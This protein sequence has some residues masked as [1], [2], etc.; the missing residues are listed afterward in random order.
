MKLLID[1][2]PVELAGGQATTFSACCREVMQHLLKRN[3]AID[4]LLLDGRPVDSV[5]QAEADFAAAA[6]CEFRTVPL[7]DAVRGLLE[8]YER[9]LR[10]LEASVENLVTESLLAE[11]ET[12]AGLWR[13]LCEAVKLAIARLP[14]LAALLTDEEIDEIAER[15]MTDFNNAMRDI[16]TALNKADLVAFSDILE[17]RLLAWLRGIREIVARQMAS[18][19]ADQHGVRP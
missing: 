13:D 6:V 12:V 18:L 4:A 11:P 1:S 16:A 8:T 15:R 17:L 10:T 9:D 19:H 7:G 3:R 14:Q 2:E 5:A